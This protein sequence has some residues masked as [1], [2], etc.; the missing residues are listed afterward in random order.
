MIVV[1]ELGDQENAILCLEAFAYLAQSCSLPERAARLLGANETL[2][3]AIGFARSQPMQADHDSAI[4][5]LTGQ[6]GEAA[7]QAAWA[8][9]STMAYGQ[10]IAYAVDRSWRPDQSPDSRLAL[11]T[12]TLRDTSSEREKD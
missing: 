8:E 6:L 12:S 10:A 1:Q 2:R 4:A 7:F 9:G 5:Q 11:S 3:R